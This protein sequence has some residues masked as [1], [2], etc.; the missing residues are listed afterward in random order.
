MPGV[1]FDLDGT[2]LDTNYLHVVAWWEAFR[3]YG[4]EVPGRLIHSFVGQGADRLVESVLGEE[5]GRIAEAHNDIYAARLHS[6][7]VLPGAADLVRATKSAGLV[8]V[9]A[10]SASAHELEHLRKALNVDD[11]V[12][13]V[14]SSDDADE[15]KPAPDI[16]QV[17]LD[18][19]D[20]TSDECLFVGDTVW[21]VEAAQGSGLPCV[22]VLSGGI[23][24]QDLRAA[25]AV[26]VYRDSAALLEDFDNSP[27]GALSP[28]R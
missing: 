20:L 6:I 16:V 24:E 4:H 22:A 17:A 1:L 19:A 27:L 15:S 26:E 3:A 11:D 2:L 28:A 21:D 23:C 10:S 14:T 8:V 18:K 13:V 12:D 9:L 25:G 7:P 5:D